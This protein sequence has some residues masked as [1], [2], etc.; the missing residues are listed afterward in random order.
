MKKLIG[1]LLIGGFT[2]M[3]CTSGTPTEAITYECTTPEEYGD[4]LATGE[5]IYWDC[6]W[7]AS[8]KADNVGAMRNDDGVPTMIYRGVSH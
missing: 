4:T 5:T 6:D 3:A 1:I 2:M 7:E 8:Y